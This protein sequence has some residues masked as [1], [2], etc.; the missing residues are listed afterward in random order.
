M[1][2]EYDEAQQEVRENWS[3]YHTCWFHYLDLFHLCNGKIMDTQEWVYAPI[4][5]YHGMILLGILLE[6]V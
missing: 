3:Q 6:R 4:R 5:S 2:K 1:S